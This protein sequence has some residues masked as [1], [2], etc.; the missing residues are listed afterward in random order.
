MSETSPLDRLALP[1]D[2]WPH[3]E[4]VPKA[5]L[6]AG[7]VTAQ[8][9]HGKDCSVILATRS[10]GYHSKPHKHAAEQ[11]NYV[12]SGQAWL[13]VEDHG[14]LGGA[15]SVS[16]IPANAVHWAWVVGDEPLT[17]LEIHTPP[18]TG[19][20]PVHAGRVS[21]C[22]TDEEEAAVRHIAT[23]WPD[24]FDAAPIEEHWVGRSYAAE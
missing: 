19:D 11:L 18:L 24:D 13:F 17:V 23:E 2:A 9:A 14:F 8:V 5:R 21:L 16:R 7:A 20:A 15:G 4:L 6:A 12:L 3:V 1:A 22:T 10:P